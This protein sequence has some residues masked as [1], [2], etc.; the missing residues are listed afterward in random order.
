V[1]E[2]TETDLVAGLALVAHIDRRCRVVA[3][4]HHGQP[5][6]GQALPLALGDASANPLQQFLRDAFAVEDACAHVDTG[7]K[8]A[9]LSKLQPQRT[10]AKPWPKQC[11]TLRLHSPTVAW[12]CAH[13]ATRMPPN[14]TQ[15]CRN[16]S[17]AWAAGCRGV[18]PTTTWS[19]PGRGRGTAMKRGG[20]A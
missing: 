15:P 18:A 1:V 12:C 8:D 20:P 9:T 5:R 19:G 11:P 4:Q 17:P 14:C 2:G 13:G 7:A 16:R 6:R 10:N 3:H